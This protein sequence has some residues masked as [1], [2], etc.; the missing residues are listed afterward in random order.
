MRRYRRKSQV[1]FILPLTLLLM[2]AMIIYSLSALMINQVLIKEKRDAII[3][4]DNR[5]KVKKALMQIASGGGF[6][7]L[8]CLSPVVSVLTL[9][10]YSLQWWE[11]YGCHMMMD[12]HSYYFMIE[13]MGLDECGLMS[14]V[15]QQY[16]D[17]ANYFRISMINIDRNIMQMTVALPKH[18]LLQCTDKMHYVIHGQQMVRQL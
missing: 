15:S 11:S 13:S 9:K 3:A 14:E 7:E 10:K 16:A 12:N 8:P 5:Q 4:R 2:Q 1:G 6:D 18:Q 17:I